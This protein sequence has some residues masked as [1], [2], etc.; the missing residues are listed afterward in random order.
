[1]ISPRRLFSGPASGALAGAA[2]LGLG[3]TPA[4]AQCLEAQAVA[5]DAQ[6]GDNYGAALG[7][8]GSRVVVGAEYADSQSFDEGQVYVVEFINGEWVETGVMTHSDGGFDHRLGH[9]VAI[10]ERRVIAGARYNTDF[11]YGTG[12]AYIFEFDATG[13]PDNA[14]PESAKLLSNDIAQ[15]DLFGQSVAIHG[16][17]ALVGAHGHDGAEF[18]AGAAY[19]FTFNGNGWPQTQKLVASDPDKDDRYGEE[20]A[21]FGDRA[22]VGARADDEAG[23]NT[24]AAYVYEADANGDLIE[25]A[26]LMAPDAVEF[27]RFGNDVDIHGDYVIVGSALSGELFEGAAYVFQ[28][29]ASGS[30]D[31]LQKLI[32]PVG[33]DGSSFGLDVSIWGDRIAVGAPTNQKDGLYGAGELFLYELAADGRFEL[34]S[35]LSSKLATGGFNFG[36]AADLYEDRVAVGARGSEVSAGYQS[37]ELLIYSGT[38]E[39]TESLDAC[40]GEISLVAGGVQNLELWAGA[41]LAGELYLMLGSATGTTPGPVVDGLEVPLVIDSYFLETLNP[42]GGA[43]LIGGFGLLDFEGRASTQVSVPAGT[44]PT[45]AGLVVHHAF[46]VLSQLTGQVLSVSSPVAVELLP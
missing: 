39:I 15:G 14:W 33:F 8:W 37:G 24:G 46:V 11:G 7:I 27:D 31:F 22:I 17:R 25:V 9:S 18:N 30:W 34:T 40:P 26:K 45:L 3:S 29:S 38:G 2:L 36:Q 32:P 20:L 41:D 43:P 13:W 4:L 19:V 5:S 42:A 16:D 23:M 21:I 10:W 6:E 28:R 35:R 12:S 44:D 1:M